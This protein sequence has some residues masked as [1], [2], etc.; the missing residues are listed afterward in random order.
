M[1]RRRYLGWLAR[2]TTLAAVLGWATTNPS[3]QLGA[4]KN[5]EWHAYGGD[6]GNTHYSP[7]DQINKD[8]FSKLE[9]AWRFKPTALGDRPDFNMQATPLMVKG[10]L[11]LT[12]GSHRNAVALN[13]ATGEML[14]MYRLDEGKRADASVRRLSGRGVGYWTDGRGDE[15]IYFVTIGYQLVCLDARPGA[16]FPASATTASST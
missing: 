11:Y 3:A 7:L 4:P 10:V 8:N 1:S 12:A 6:L 16:R 9:V 14:W 13:A 5:G 15:R 2:L